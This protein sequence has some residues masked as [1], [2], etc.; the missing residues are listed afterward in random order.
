MKRKYARSPTSHSGGQRAAR[1]T[2]EEDQ[3][4]GELYRPPCGCSAPIAR[5]RLRA[6]NLDVQRRIAEGKL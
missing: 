5:Q 3:A 6:H 2:T 4:M 1:D